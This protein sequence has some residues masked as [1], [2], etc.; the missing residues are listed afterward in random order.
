MIYWVRI[1]YDTSMEDCPCSPEEE[2]KLINTIH[3]APL[4]C[5]QHTALSLGTISGYL[6]HTVRV[7]FPEA[8]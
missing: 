1:L 8:I 4:Q 7:A 6:I 3:P 2:T 5:V